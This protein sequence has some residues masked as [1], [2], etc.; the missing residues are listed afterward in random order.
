MGDPVDQ[1]S[2]A[3]PSFLDL[4]DNCVIDILQ[5]LQYHDLVNLSNTCTR[6][7]A[8]CIRVC[9]NKYSEIK[10][11]ARLQ[12]PLE[13]TV[14]PNMIQELYLL[15]V[16]KDYKYFKDYINF[17]G[18]V[19]RNILR[20]R[21]VKPYRNVEKDVILLFCSTTHQLTD[22]E[23]PN[24]AK[25]GR[26][27]KKLWLPDVVINTNVIK[28]CF[29]NNPEMQCEYDGSYDQNV[30]EILVNLPKL[31]SLRLLRTSESLQLNARLFDTIT[32]FENLEVLSLDGYFVDNIVLENAVF[33][34]KLKKM[35]IH[36]SV[37]MSFNVFTSIVER[38][39]CLE[40]LDLGACRIIWHHG[41]CKIY[42]TKC[43]VGMSCNVIF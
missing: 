27:L 25:N 41:K 33:P 20:I 17:A 10:V 8:V 35:K 36:L 31:I 19:G 11:R 30:M 18:M 1:T 5:F 42:F 40:E 15:F 7:R 26:N 29:T 2:T 23:E 4:D 38:L 37:V 3:N 6:L 28:Y 21:E 43:Y 16:Q 39:Q 12:N 13:R 14:S 9:C 22:D 32:L 34:L 24:T